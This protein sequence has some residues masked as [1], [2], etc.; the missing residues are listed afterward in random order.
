M[1]G[2]T[3][4]HYRIVEKIGAG[5]MGEVYRAHD[6]RLERD[7]AL[8]VLPEAFAQDASRLARFKREAHLLA[9]LLGMT[10]A[11]VVSLRAVALPGEE[12][13]RYR[14][15]TAYLQIW[16]AASEGYAVVGGSVVGADSEAAYLL[17]KLSEPSAPY[18]YLFL[19]EK[20]APKLQHQLDVYGAQGFRVN[21][22]GLRN[23][24]PGVFSWR[25]PT[26]VLLEKAPGEAGHFN[27]R[28]LA[29][30]NLPALQMQ[31][32]RARLEGYRLVGVLKPSEYV[33]IFEKADS[34]AKASEVMLG[35]D[36][37]LERKPA[38]T[39]TPGY[40]I[41]QTF[42]SSTL[43]K[44]INQ[45]TAAG[46]RLVSA[47]AGRGLMC[48][49]LLEKA[50][51]SEPSIEH[52]LLGGLRASTLEKKLNQM[53]GEGFRAWPDAIFSCAG[54]N[55]VIMGR[56]SNPT[57]RYQYLVL[58]TNR[59]ATLEREINE[60]C[61]RGYAIVGLLGSRRAVLERE[62]VT[63]VDTPTEDEP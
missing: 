1:I 34:P 50:D 44:E 41:L 35:E 5:G 22:Y 18:L 19:S 37:P 45:A 51:V 39:V 59:R 10:V 28:V 63:Q 52:R 36:V 2:Q 42:R 47:V 48:R 55:Q 27:Y 9:L 56:T 20:K 24:R 40:V 21:P 26:E 38:P 32:A 46:Y 62:I 16:E 53:A 4:G 12:C 61:Q 14:V 60:A 15:A 8:K 3:L 7:V 25:P 54:Q 49:V 57:A 58:A 30:K 29:G 17:E 31:M 23:G 13:R 6:E 43:E 33:V 11:L